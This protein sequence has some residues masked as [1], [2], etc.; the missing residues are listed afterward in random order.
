MTEWR[1]TDALSSMQSALSDGRKSSQ[2]NPNA[3][4]RTVIKSSKNKL[5]HLI[6]KKNTRSLGIKQ[7]QVHYLV[8]TMCW[9]KNIDA[10]HS[11]NV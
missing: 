8:E 6:I 2:V 10:K 11:Y 9:S 4:K 3:E 5:L 7:R 1:T